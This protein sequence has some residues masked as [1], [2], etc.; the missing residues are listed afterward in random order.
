MATQIEAQ[1]SDSKMTTQIEL[2]NEG[3][4]IIP[5]SGCMAPDQMVPEYHNLT[6]LTVGP[7]LNPA[8]QPTPPDPEALDKVRSVFMSF[9][10]NSDENINNMDDAAKHQMFV[11]VCN[12]YKS[13]SVINIAEN[14]Y[15]GKKGEENGIQQEGVADKSAEEAHREDTRSVNKRYKFRSGIT[16]LEIKLQ[17]YHQTFLDP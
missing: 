14:L 5:P 17:V 3:G 8:L 15:Q 13:L 7:G 11:D 1:F 9:V 16:F 12:M 10:D 2:L 6:P 4:Q